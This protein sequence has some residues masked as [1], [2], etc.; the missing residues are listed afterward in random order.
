M[1]SRVQH[2]LSSSQHS[3]I[4]LK[5]IHDC[6]WAKLQSSKIFRPLEWSKCSAASFSKYITEDSHS[7]NSNCQNRSW[8]C[9]ERF[10]VGVSATQRYF[11]TFFFYSSWHLSIKLHRNIGLL[12][13]TGKK[14]SGMSLSK[15]L[16]VFKSRINFLKS[17]KV[18]ACYLSSFCPKSIQ[19]IM[20]MCQT[21]CWAFP[22]MTQP[23]QV[24][25]INANCFSISFFFF[26]W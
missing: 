3:L 21:F 1:N 20:A 2:S 24:L 4:F 5:T 16:Q 19:R 18:F 26:Q 25:Y 23:W 9:S 17:W 14:L 22:H 10:M 15:I 8:K 12:F 11:P 6:Q 7:Q 13:R